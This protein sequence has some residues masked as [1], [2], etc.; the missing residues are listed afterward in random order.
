VRIIRS[1]LDSGDPG[2]VRERLAALE[3]QLERAVDLAIQTGGIAAVKRKIAALESEQARLLIELQRAGDPPDLDALATTVEARVRDIRLA[4]DGAP[5][6]VRTA[7]GTML[8][9][10]KISVSPDDERRF[11]VEGLLQV[12]MN[13]DARNREGSGRL[14]CYVA[15]ARYARVCTLPV[16]LILP[17]EG[18]VSPRV[19]SQ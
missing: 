4:F 6:E 13:E 10:G 1:R 18:R 12:P 7:L 5:G 3:I 2:A 11:R 8:R 16:P 15:G 9:G 17:V 19:A 14:D